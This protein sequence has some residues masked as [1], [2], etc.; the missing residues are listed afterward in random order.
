MTHALRSHTCRCGRVVFGNG[1]WSSHKRSCDI[2]RRGPEKPAV[3]DDPDC[4]RQ[5]VPSA[6][7]RNTCSPEGK[8][9]FCS[10]ACAERMYWKRDQHEALKKMGL[11]EGGK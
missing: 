2:F 10:R 5:F 6:G 7:I 11:T 1:G 9:P 8:F 4:A 3:C